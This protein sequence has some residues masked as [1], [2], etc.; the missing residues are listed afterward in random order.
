MPQRHLCQDRV[1]FFHG[2]LS[3]PPSVLESEVLGLCH[4]VQQTPVFWHAALWS[5]MDSLH[6]STPTARTSV[7]HHRA[8]WQG[9][10]A[11]GKGHSPQWAHKWRNIPDMPQM[12]S[13]LATSFPRAIPTALPC[14][15]LPSEG[16][17]SIGESCGRGGRGSPL[18]APWLAVTLV[19]SAKLRAVELAEA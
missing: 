4:G 10:P 16:G 11:P 19:C 12:A 3:Q 5:E 6:A 15:G 13:P 7:W 1:W 9:E 17:A 8:W 14:Q 2:L 18:H